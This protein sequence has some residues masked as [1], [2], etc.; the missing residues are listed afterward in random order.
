MDN[1]NEFTR[2]LEREGKQA[3]AKYLEA[4]LHSIEELRKEFILLKK[5]VKARQ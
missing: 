2:R 3:V 1:Q 5:E 4:I